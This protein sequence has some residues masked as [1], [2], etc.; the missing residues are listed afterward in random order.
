MKAGM[1]LEM[2]ASLDIFLHS[3]LDSNLE[4]TADI[5]LMFIQLLSARLR[6]IKDNGTWLGME[7]IVLIFMAIFSPTNC[8][9]S[10]DFDYQYFQL[11]YKLFRSWNLGSI[12]EI[13]HHIQQ[14]INSI[15]SSSIDAIFHEMANAIIQSKSELNQYRLL[16][17]VNLF[18]FIFPE[19][20]AEKIKKSMAVAKDGNM[21]FF[22]LQSVFDDVIFLE[23][24]LFSANAAYFET[25]IIHMDVQ[26][27]KQLVLTSNGQYCKQTFEVLQ[28]I[29]TK[30]G[31]ILSS[32]H[33][34]HHLSAIE[35]ELAVKVLA[36]DLELWLLFLAWC[37]SVCRESENVEKIELEQE[38]I[39]YFC[40]SICKLFAAEIKTIQESRKADK[41][42]DF[43]EQNRES[44]IYFDIKSVIEQA[45]VGNEFLVHARKQRNIETNDSSVVFDEPSIIVTLDEEKCNN[46]GYESERDDEKHD[47]EEKYDI[48]PFKPELIGIP[49][50]NKE[51]SKPIIS[52]IVQNNEFMKENES[53]DFSYIIFFAKKRAKENR[54]YRMRF[55]GGSHQ[56]STFDCIDDELQIYVCIRESNLHS[57][58]N[59]RR[60]IHNNES[61]DE[62]IVQIFSVGKNDTDIIPIETK[63]SEIIQ[64]MKASNIN[65]SRKLFIID[66]LHEKKSEVYYNHAISICINFILNQ[67]NICL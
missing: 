13:M 49:P 62:Q 1:I 44:I 23:L 26:F 53:K 21:D 31:Q 65:Y 55:F 11:C 33:I 25:R 16:L 17:W 8:V 9:K 66:S 43:V 40:C 59:I 35:Y 28:T 34:I 39:Q 20:A 37:M 67:V 32:V 47:E 61:N 50:P 41:L 3:S 24:E 27:I 46:N 4:K 2:I 10:S 15:F 6:S 12:E 22:Q 58:L 30:I 54:E 51:N 29:L 36:D 42:L 60:S 64:R 56:Y 63:N 57:N 18:S 19:N 7:N 45:I 38:A 52:N 5:S 48:L 14:W